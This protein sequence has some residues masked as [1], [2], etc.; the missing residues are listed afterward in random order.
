MSDQEDN[1]Q[2]EFGAMSKLSGSFLAHDEIVD[3]ETETESM[4]LK[5]FFKAN[6]WLKIFIKD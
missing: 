2:N 6:Y 3:D 1:T 4:L 5:V